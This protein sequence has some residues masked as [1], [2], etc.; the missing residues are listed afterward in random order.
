MLEQAPDA[1]MTAYEVAQKVQEKLQVLG[2]VIENIITESLKPKLKRIFGIMQRKGLIPPKPD[3]LK[4]VS[5][6]IE[7]IS[8]LS[9]AQKGS[10]TGGLERIVALIGNMVAVYPEVR[11]VL[12]PDA[13]VREFNDLLANP[14]K[15]LRGPEEVAKMTQQEQQAQQQQQQQQAVAQGAQTVS[16]GADAANTLAN[17]NIGGGQT[18]LAQLLG[19]GQ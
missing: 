7:F 3:S 10:A 2:P 8:M 6:D 17:T 15:I 5:L 9:L 11:H 19:G 12:D 13:Y 16:V 1:K 14:E 18:A 4:D